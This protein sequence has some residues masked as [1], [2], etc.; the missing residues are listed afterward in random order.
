MAKHASGVTADNAGC[1]SKPGGTPSKSVLWRACCFSPLAKRG[2]NDVGMSYR[3]AVDNFQ[4]V[5]RYG[6]IALSA[7][8]SSVELARKRLMKLIFNYSRRHPRSKFVSF[9]EKNKNETDQP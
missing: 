7:S 5:N 4:R 6:C 1:E 8:V 2:P 3:V 9:F